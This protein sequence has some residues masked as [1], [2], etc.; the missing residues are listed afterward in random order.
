MCLHPPAAQRAELL[1]EGVL[2]ALSGKEVNFTLAP[3][4][5]LLAT[6]GSSAYI[7]S[8]VSIPLG[9]EVSRCRCCR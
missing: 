9:D 1:A 6:I 2:P 5:Q 4:G 7:A 8:P 3:N